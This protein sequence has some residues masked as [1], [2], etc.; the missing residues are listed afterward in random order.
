V[1]DVVYEV[2]AVEVLVVDVDAVV[3]DVDD[4]SPEAAVSGTL[5]D[6]VALETVVPASLEVDLLHA[7]AIAP[8]DTVAIGRPSR[9]TM[10]TDR[11]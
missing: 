7:V 6:A 9:E 2:E 3:V 8:I 4:P 1:V 10:R 11:T 5:D